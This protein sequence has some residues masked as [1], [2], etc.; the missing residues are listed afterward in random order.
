M[1]YYRGLNNN[2]NDNVDNDNDPMSVC[3]V[4]HRHRASNY[5]NTCDSEHQSLA[6]SLALADIDIDIY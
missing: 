3:R 1:A 5:R 2:V 4:N 6:V